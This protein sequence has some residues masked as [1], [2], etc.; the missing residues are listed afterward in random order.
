MGIIENSKPCDKDESPINREIII[1]SNGEDFVDAM[2]FYF[3]Q[4]ESRLKTYE[5]VLRELIDLGLLCNV[6]VALTP[7]NPDLVNID[8]SLN[9]LEQ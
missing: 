3:P 7:T 9:Q 5:S 8:L 4:E 1:E 6:K 2:H